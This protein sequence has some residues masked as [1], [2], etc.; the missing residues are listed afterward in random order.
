MHGPQVVRRAQRRALVRVVGVPV[1]AVL[2][3][4]PQEAVAA[5]VEVA[6]VGA[7]VV[8]VLVLVVALFEKEASMMTLMIEMIV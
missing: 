3:L 4:R 5:D 2:L 7:L 6:Q 1:V 8:V